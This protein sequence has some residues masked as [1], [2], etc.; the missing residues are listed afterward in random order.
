MEDHMEL[1]NQTRTVTRTSSEIGQWVVAGAF[2]ATS[3]LWYPVLALTSVLAFAF[4]LSM[5]ALKKVWNWYD[6]CYPAGEKPSKGVMGGREVL[7]PVLRP[8]PTFRY[9]VRTQAP[10]P[11]FKTETEKL[12]EWEER[13]RY[14]YGA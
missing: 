5:W 2:I 4:G 10:T 13:E 9:L 14:R 7:Q 12:H 3:F 6:A 1:S 11:V 8:T